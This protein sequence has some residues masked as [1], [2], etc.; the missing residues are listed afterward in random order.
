MKRVL[1]GAGRATAFGLIVLMTAGC[2]GVL[3][4]SG[5]EEGANPYRALQSV[6]A[7]EQ[8]QQKMDDLKEIVLTDAGTARGALRV[9]HRA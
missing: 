4:T 9:V 3:S 1:G 2:A 8:L 6:Q 7:F 5:S